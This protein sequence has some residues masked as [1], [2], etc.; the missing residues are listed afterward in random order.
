[1]QERGLSDSLLKGILDGAYAFCGPEIVQFDITNKCNNNCICC[2]NNSPLLG[3]IN[4][5]REKEMHDELPYSLIIKTIRELRE[6]GTKTLFF[7]GGGEPFKHPHIM[8]ILR[9]AKDCDM[10]IF[11]NTNFALIDKDRARELVN[12]KIEHIHVSLLSGTAAT[13]ALVHPNKT[14]DTFYRIK[15]MLHYIAQLKREKEQHLYNPLPHIT[16]Y[17]VVFNKNY[18]EIDKI[19]DLAF[20]VKA[21][22]IEFAPIDVIPEKTDVLLL[23]KE[24][25]RYVA[26]ETDFQLRRIEKYNVNEPV[27]IQVEPIY[28]FLKRINSP[29]ALESKYESETV[30]RQPCYVG[31]AFLRILANGNVNPC[32]KAHRISVGN[33]YELAIKDIWNNPQQKLF[34]EKSFLLDGTD[35]YFRLIGNNPYMQFGC[36][37][38]CDNIQINFD[39]HNRY[40]QVL[41]ENGRIK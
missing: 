17:Q 1:M 19:V 24:Q 36:L 13:Y 9:F 30:T 23:N 3:S 10:R 31:W 5:E 14:E 28:N 18:K 8:E 22:S 35:P 7:A 41:K 21:D 11:I 2:W 34:R 15:E 40:G 27:K 20:E 26:K 25:I 4:P 38:S 33:I 37:N 32:L 29:G 6:M 39:M 16:L 12:L